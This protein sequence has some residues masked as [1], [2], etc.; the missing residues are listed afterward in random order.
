M[1]PEDRQDCVAAFALPED[2]RVRDLIDQ[3]GRFSA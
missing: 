3:L 2:F 1:G